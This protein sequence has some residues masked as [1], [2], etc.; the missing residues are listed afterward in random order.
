MSGLFEKPGVEGVLLVDA[1]NAFNSLN[2][3]AALH[4]IPRI[5]PALAKIFANT[6]STPIR[7][8]VSGGGEVLYQEGICQGDPLAVAIYAVAVT[9]TAYQKAGPGMPFCGT[10]VVRR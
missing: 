7:L 5:C 6:Y 9:Y 2:R 8:F 4:N 1:C 3:K 10:V